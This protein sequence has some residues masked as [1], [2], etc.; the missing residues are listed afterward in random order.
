VLA[1]LHSGEPLF[2]GENEAAQ[3]GQIYTALGPPPASLVAASRKGPIYFRADERTPGGYALA[4]AS[5]GCAGPTLNGYFAKGGARPALPGGRAPPPARSP[6]AARAP[7]CAL[8]RR[9]QSIERARVS[10]AARGA[11]RWGEQGHAESDYL[12]FTHLVAQM[13]RWDPATRIT[14]EEAA[15]HPFFKMP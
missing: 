12:E 4:G 7:W 8:D 11:R 10:P 15:A 14:P 13:L 2:S 3:V 9:L 1:E 6:R 5:L